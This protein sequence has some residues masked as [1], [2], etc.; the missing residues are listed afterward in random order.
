MHGVCRD[1]ASFPHACIYAQVETVR[2]PE[3]DEAADV[4]EETEEDDGADAEE[5]DDD[6]VDLRFVP[7]NPED[8]APS[9]LMCSLYN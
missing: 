1:T 9:P 2:E 3:G 7:P 5:I 8:G 4:G 6:T